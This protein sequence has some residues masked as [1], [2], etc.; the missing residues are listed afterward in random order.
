MGSKTSPT[1]N[2]LEAP[3]RRVHASA[4]EQAVRCEQRRRTKHGYEHGCQYPIERCAQRTVSSVFLIRLW[5]E[6]AVYVP[7]RCFTSG[8]RADTSG[9]VGQNEDNRVVADKKAPWTSGLTDQVQPHN[10]HTQIHHYM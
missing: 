7:N 9:T 4:D 2:A 10:A 3:E 5:A 6:T 1:F 8:T